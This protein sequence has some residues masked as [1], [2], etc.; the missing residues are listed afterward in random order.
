MKKR[1][2]RKRKK[3]NK[4]IVAQTYAEL[5]HSISSFA[6]FKKFLRPGV[7]YSYVR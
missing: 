2:P 1:T 7:Y 3:R 4:K 6:H 5:Q